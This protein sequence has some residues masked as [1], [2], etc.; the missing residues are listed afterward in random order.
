MV[1]LDTTFIID[2]L[3]RNQAAERKLKNL[4]NGKEGAPSI[5]V[6]TLAELFYGAYKAQNQ[7]IE[8]EKI[9]QIITGIQILDMDEDA[10]EKFGELMSAL[11][12]AGQ[13]VA[14]RDV[15][16]AAIALAN[17]ELTIVTRNKK[18][19]DRIPNVKVITY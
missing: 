17:E 10:A 13:K 3:H 18:D 16:I 1:C 5:T 9:T 15:M 7:K 8:K 4:A 2:L 6:I 11:D 12:K 14:D 19:F